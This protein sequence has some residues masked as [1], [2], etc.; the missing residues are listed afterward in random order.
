MANYWG[1][2][3]MNAKQ[4]MQASEAAVKNLV[5]FSTILIDQIESESKTKVKATTMR[6]AMPT[7]FR[8]LANKGVFTARALPNG[9][10]AYYL[11]VKTG[12]KPKNLTTDRVEATIAAYLKGE[13]DP[14]KLK[15]AG[16]K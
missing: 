1:M 7:V 14:A 8:D 2:P 9:D 5:F 6:R 3:E 13:R 12:A 16:A 4:L 10:T 11:I 15:S